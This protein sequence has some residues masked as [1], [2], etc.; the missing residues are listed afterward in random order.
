MAKI[1]MTGVPDPRRIC[2]KPKGLAKA[3]TLK[4]A[5]LSSVLAGCSAFGV[6]L[7]FDS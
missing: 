3:I 6:R 1:M 4:D 7:V 2:R 5:P